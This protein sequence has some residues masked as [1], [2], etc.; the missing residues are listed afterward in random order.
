VI[1]S[2]LLLAESLFPGRLAAVAG[3]AH[4][5]ALAFIGVLFL[6]PP[7]GYLWF[8][9]RRRSRAPIVAY[10]RCACGN[11][12][13]PRV[14]SCQKCA[15]TRRLT[16]EE[17]WESSKLSWTLSKAGAGFRAVGWAV[18]Y[19]A[20][21][22][23]LL[24]LDGWRTGGGALRE[25]FA[26]GGLLAAGAMVVSAGAALGRRGGGL[27]T[28]GVLLLAAGTFGAFLLGFSA[29]WAAAPFPPLSPLASVSLFPDG[30]V[31]VKTAE[32]RV[33]EGRGELRDGVV[34]F[35]LRCA[36][37]SWPLLHVKQVL[38]LSLGNR[39]L[40]EGWI[41]G[42]L[43]SGARKYTSDA[44]HVLHVALRDD[45]LFQPP[46]GPYV[47]RES[48]DNGGLILEAAIKKS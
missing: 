14:G 15:L 42:F 33:A 43:E 34:S 47:L 6:L 9:W 23:V 27:V 13:A 18:Y 8:S 48:T 5:A 35:R 37:L 3:N 7:L 28:R 20:P 26:A 10:W 21:A 32:G 22:A 45:I 36:S 39:P 25:L 24:M 44:P 30:R 38:P 19:A 12:N 41:A 31:L 16:W 1:A 17:S 29:L 46:G 2:L 11:E 4:V 40:Q